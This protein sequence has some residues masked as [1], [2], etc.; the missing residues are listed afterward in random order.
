MVK[1]LQLQEDDTSPGVY[2]ATFDDL[3]LGPLTLRAAGS[4]VQSLLA[5]ENHKDSVEQILTV[6][7]KGSTELSNPL[8]NLPLLKQ[9]ADASGGAVVPP[10]AI[11]AALAQ[12]GAVGHP[13]IGSEP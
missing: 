3:P 2:H 11:P 6:D 10:G 1:L 5:E 7:P 12:I 9:L 8:C 13:A 4:M